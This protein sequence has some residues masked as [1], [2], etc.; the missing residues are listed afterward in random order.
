AADN[1]DD[2]DQDAGDGVAADEL[3]STVHGAVEVGLPGDFGPPG[4]GFF[5]IDQPGVEVGIDAH[6]L[7]RHGVQGEAGGHLGH[8]LGAP[9]DDDELADDQDEEDDEADYGVAAH[10]EAAEL[11]DRLPG[12]AV[13]QDQPGRRDVERQPHQ[14]RHQ[15]DRRE[16][17]DVQGPAYV[18]GGQQRGQRKGQVPHQQQVQQP[19][20]QRDHHHGHH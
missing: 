2:G 4:P 3:G 10:H 7:T 9:G 20:G 6:L 13:Q 8:A 1:V 16:R 15:Q 5:F 14:G 17:G 19:R 11:L 12:V 18:K